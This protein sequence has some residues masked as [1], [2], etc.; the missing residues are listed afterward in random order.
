MNSKQTPATQRRHVVWPVAAILL[1]LALLTG[2]LT[3]AWINR[4][5][6]GFTTLSTLIRKADTAMEAFDPLGLAKII[7][8]AV[9][10]AINGK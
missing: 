7:R 9:E 2:N 6:D 1:P 3:G 10:A 4:Q 8:T 5:A